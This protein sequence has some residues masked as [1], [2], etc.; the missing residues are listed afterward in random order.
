[1][2][3]SFRCSYFSHFIRRMAD[4]LLPEECV[5]SAAL[6]RPR[7]QPLCIPAGRIPSLATRQARVPLL[8]PQQAAS[9]C[10]LYPP[11]RQ[12]LAGPRQ[13]PG[14]LRPGLT[15][16]PPRPCGSDPGGDCSAKGGAARTR[17]A[18]LLAPRAAGPPRPAVPGS[19]FALF[20]R[21]SPPAGQ[22]EWGGG[23][24]G[25]ECQL[26]GPSAPEP[27]SDSSAPQV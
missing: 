14:A 13:R 5:G 3:D 1:M 10:H 9:G 7:R 18:P 4:P 21:G 11:S 22:L 26:A 24:V 15:L 23:G 2:T 25:G 20:Q 12:R 19:S 17:G 6:N 8:G 27:S 16:S